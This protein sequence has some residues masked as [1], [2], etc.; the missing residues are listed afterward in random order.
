ML[1][2]LAL[3]GFAINTYVW[4]T[5][6]VNSTLIFEFDPRDYRSFTELFEVCQGITLNGVLNLTAAL[7][8]QC[9]CK[10]KKIRMGEI[11]QLDAMCLCTQM[12]TKLVSLTLQGFHIQ[13]TESST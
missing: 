4:R 9:K 6:G 3:Y 2:V 1:I 10:Q 8:L 5:T 12:F 11:F 13:F 7:H